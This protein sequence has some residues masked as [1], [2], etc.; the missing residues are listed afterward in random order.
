MSS[1]YT[2]ALKEGLKPSEVLTVSQWSDKYRI[3]GSKAA[4]E[5]GRWRTSRTPYLKEIM[6]CLSEH[7]PVEEVAVMKGAQVGFSECGVNWLG[8][9]MHHAPGPTMMVQPTV[10]MAK[11]ASKQR[12]APLIEDC[13]ELKAI[14]SDSKSRESSNTI[15]M[16]EF[17]GG[18]LVLAGANS[19]AG[20]R[21][22]PVKY[23]FLDEV[24]AY[25][26]DLDGEGSA[27]ELAKARTRTFSRRKI[28]LGSTPTLSGASAIESAFEESDKRYYH[29]PCP[30]CQAKQRI[31]WKNIKWDKKDYST[32]RLYCVKCGEGIQEFHKTK[33]LENGQWIASNP[34]TKKRGYHISSLYSPV[35]W[36]S[37]AEA[38]EQ[39]D[40]SKDNPTKLKTFMNTVLG[41]TW[42]EKGEVPDW[43]RL[44]NRR[45]NYTIGTI[46]MR[47]M[48]I[49][50]GVD[51]QGDRLEATI[52]AYGK[53][54]E[55]WVIDH[56]VLMGDTSNITTAGPWGKLTE[57]ISE[58][59]EHEGGAKLPIRM[60]AVDSGY[61]TSIV[62]EYTRKFHARKVI[63]TKGQ[64]SLAM[65]VAAPKAV[66]VKING[67]RYARG[68]KLWNIGSSFMK[69]ELYGW[70]KQD[71]PTDNEIK[72]FGFPPGYM[73]FP[74][75]S[76]EFFQQ[77]CSEQVVARIVKGYRKYSWTKLRERNEVLD[78]VIMARV[79]ASLVGLD[80]FTDKNWA[81]LAQEV[82][83]KNPESSENEIPDQKKVDNPK[84][85]TRKKPKI[86]ESLFW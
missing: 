31:E 38:A 11:R 9:I 15:L 72:A 80:R 19:S 70:L 51:V 35:G 52:M 34:I 28:L 63:A 53:N 74:M 4:A 83:V 5:P 77:L 73:H 10:D 27:I 25:P 37:W 69:T 59:F 6:D 86:K 65:I 23:L 44:Y 40:K 79:C 22:M 1:A 67:K 78:C 14:V 8:Y 36:Y 13:P 85:K 84:K 12:L 61:K 2:I 3:L 18:I 42:V 17:L 55:S 16:K 81:K 48:F 62:Y 49:T 43:K 71:E 56:R 75:E 66:D 7:S 24:D 26:V 68:A 30:Y 82:G 21:S 45:E 33:M 54:K 57:L 32:T 29:V 76:E 60:T 39:W 58:E 46:P 64:D 20:L 50:M 47:A 41:E